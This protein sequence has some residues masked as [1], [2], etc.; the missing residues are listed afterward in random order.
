M[1]AAGAST[2]LRAVSS[3]WVRVK[4]QLRKYGCSFRPP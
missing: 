4:K 2:R 3:V 1:K